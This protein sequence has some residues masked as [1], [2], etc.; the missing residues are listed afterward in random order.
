M[1]IWY[2][3]RVVIELDKKMIEDL[4]ILTLITGISFAVGMAI[5]VIYGLTHVISALLSGS[6]AGSIILLIYYST[7]VYF[8]YIY[9]PRN[10]QFSVL[11]KNH[12]ITAI[13]FKSDYCD[14]WVS[15][16]FLEYKIIFYTPEVEKFSKHWQELLYWHEYAHLKGIIPEKDAWEFSKKKILNKYGNEVLKQILWEDI[17]KAVY[18][19]FKGKP[20]NAIIGKLIY[21]EILDPHYVKTT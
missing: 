5:T 11:C 18:S 14:A 19:G 1:I 9:K 12:G 7:V 15:V 10:N 13:C 6:I 20:E 17:A 4:E 3:F 8:L 21:K 2:V 16:L